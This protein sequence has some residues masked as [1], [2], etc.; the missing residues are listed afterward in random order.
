ML[1][2][3]LEGDAGSAFKRHAAP[4]DSAKWWQFS[5]PITVTSPPSA[6]TFGNLEDYLTQF[7]SVSTGVWFDSCQCPDCSI[8]ELAVTSPK[9]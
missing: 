8:E 6:S 4:C 1:D 5:C 2:V 7:D 9:P 3:T